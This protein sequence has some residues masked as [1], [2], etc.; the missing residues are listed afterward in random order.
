MQ[1]EV[2]S[3]SPTVLIAIAVIWVAQA[4]CVALYASAKR[5]PWLP[6]FLASLFL[7]F[8]LPVLLLALAPAMELVYTMEEADFDSDVGD[9][10]QIRLAR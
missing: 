2:D 9:D 1:R 6:V 4:G 3:M 10:F 5:Y 8:P 7:G